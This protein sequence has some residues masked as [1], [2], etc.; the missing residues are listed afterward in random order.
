M[1]KIPIYFFPGMSSTSL[2]F[3]RLEWDTSR[4][5]LHFLEWLPCK[6]N[7]DLITYTQ[8][9]IPLIQQKNPILVGVSFGGIIAQELA[10]LIDV[11]KIIIISSVRSNREFPKRFK[12]AKYTKLYKLLPTG[13]VEF[14]LHLIARYGNE[15]QKRRVE[16]YN[17]YLSIRDPHYLNWCIRTVLNWD[18]KEDLKGVIHIHGTKDE[19]FPFKN[20]RNAIEVKGGTHAM[21]LIKYKWFNQNLQKIILNSINEKES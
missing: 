11:Q 10:K 15:K 19:I 5:E 16:L 1:N 13:G 12:W 14:I 2:I 8:K 3:E 7:E 6:K 9:Y 20:I 4:F 18:Q 17:R 21:I